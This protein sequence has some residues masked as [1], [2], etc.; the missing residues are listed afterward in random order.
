M[1]WVVFSRGAIVESDTP[2]PE[3]RAGRGAIAKPP[4][5]SAAATGGGGVSIGFPDYLRPEWHAVDYQAGREITFGISGQPSQILRECVVTDPHGVV[6][7]ARVPL[8]EPSSQFSL[9]Y[10]TEFGGA[11]DLDP[12]PDGRYQI[13]W[14]AVGG[15]VLQS[16]TFSMSGGFYTKGSGQ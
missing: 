15:A 3:L 13:R 7:V 1:R 5:D 11:E 14:I 10:P 12:L 9:R 6:R 2:Q 4:T 16:D 8:G